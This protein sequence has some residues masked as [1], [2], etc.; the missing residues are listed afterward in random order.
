MASPVSETALLPRLDGGVLAERVGLVEA[1]ILVAGR[2]RYACQCKLFFRSLIP[3]SYL[4]NG[5][6]WAILFFSCAT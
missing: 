6:G 4:K 1:V 3:L 5:H 2:K